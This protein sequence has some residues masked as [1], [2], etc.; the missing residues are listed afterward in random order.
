MCCAF[1]RSFQSLWCL[2]VLFI[3]H[4]HRIGRVAGSLGKYISYETYVCLCLS[5]LVVL[6]LKR[7]LSHPD[8]SYVQCALLW[9]VDPSSVGLH[10]RELFDFIAICFC[11]TLRACCFLYLCLCLPSRL[12][13]LSVC[14]HVFLSFVSCFSF[15]IQLFLITADELFTDLQWVYWLRAPCSLARSSQGLCC[16][17]LFDCCASVMLLPTRI[18]FRNVAIFQVFINLQNHSSVHVKYWA[19]LLLSSRFW[20]YNTLSEVAAKKGRF[21]EISETLTVSSFQKCYTC[22]YVQINT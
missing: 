4:A 19:T 14:P 8:M 12:V 18:V 15:F 9:I 11:Q 22:M 1:A 13:C 2:H 20:I 5:Y 7:A 10:C 17:W 3:H 16:V 6:L 21:W